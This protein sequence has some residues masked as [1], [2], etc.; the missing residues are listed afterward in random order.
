LLQ[1]SGQPWIAFR[2]VSVGIAVGGVVGVLF[3]P[4]YGAIGAAWSVL[5]GQMA[6]GFLADF[7]G[8][9]T[10]LHATA[11]LRALLPFWRG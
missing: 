11:K 4:N 5:C 7:I 10:Q 1:A 8:T 2:R 9:E 3:I 6:A